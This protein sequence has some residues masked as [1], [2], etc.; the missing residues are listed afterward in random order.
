MYSNCTVVK[1]KFLNEYFTR[2]CAVCSKEFSSDSFHL[3][4]LTCSISRW[5]CTTI[6]FNIDKVINLNEKIY[7]LPLKSNLYQLTRRKFFF[8]ISIQISIYIFV[9]YFVTRN[10]SVFDICIPRRE[11]SFK[12]SAECRNVIESLLYCVMLSLLSTII[13]Q[14]LVC[15]RVLSLQ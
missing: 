2:I 6:L 1:K 14:K 5:I 7:L 9:K 11:N 12:Q 3:I 4:I 10:K 8:F 15:K 13:V